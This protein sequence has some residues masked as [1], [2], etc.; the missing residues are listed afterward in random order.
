MLNPIFCT[1]VLPHTY[2][3]IHTIEARRPSNRLHVNLGPVQTQLK[4]RFRKP[5]RRTAAPRVPI[6]R[7]NNSSPAEHQ[8]SEQPVPASLIFRSKPT[9]WQSSLPLG[10][11]AR[12]FAKMTV[13]A[14]ATLLLSTA[15]RIGAMLFGGSDTERLVWSARDPL[16]DAFGLALFGKFQ[17]P[18]THVEFG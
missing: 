14:C 18:D 12:G 6:A 4:F 3:H 9:D 11:G 16:S 2:L 17:M 8:A 15:G 10:N 13:S 5:V 1:P 7:N